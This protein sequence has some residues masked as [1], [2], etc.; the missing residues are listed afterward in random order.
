MA[1][2]LAAEPPY[3]ICLAGGWLDQPWVSKIASGPVVTVNIYPTINFNLRAGMATSSRELWKGELWNKKV[4]FDQP[5]ELARLLFGYENPPGSKHISGS[6]DHLGLTV[7]GASRLHYDGGFWPT[8]ITTLDDEDT[9]RWLESVLVLVELNTRPDGYDPLCEQHLEP[10]NIEALAAA[11]EE[12]WQGIVEKDIRK[13]GRGLT[14]THLAWRKM[15]PHTTNDEINAALA[16]FEGVSY[17]RTTSGCGGGYVVLAT[18]Q[19]IPNAVRIKVRR[20]SD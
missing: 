12:C 6:Q 2:E 4:F 3:R 11:G 13:L 14:N 8:S 16:T 9:A 10:E 18:D 15:L 17:G 7:P 1:M 5:V 19:E 20:T